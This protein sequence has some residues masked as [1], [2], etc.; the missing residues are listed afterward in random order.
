M[1]G[2]PLRPRLRTPAGRVAAALLAGGAL[3]GVGA[4]SDSAPSGPK[5]D[6]GAGA[7]P[8]VAQSGL[9]KGLA[10]PMAAY[11]ENYPQRVTI[12]RAVGLLTRDCM[13]RFGLSYDPP[14]PD[15]N[16]ASIYDDTNMVRRYG[17]TD[18]ESAAKLGYGLGTESY[19]PP[20]APKMSA[21]QVAV[22]SGRVELKPDAPEA[23]PTFNGIPIPR[24][25]C[26][27]EARNKVGGI[28]D[29]GLSG[30]LDNESFDTSKAAPEVQAALAQWSSCM[31][32]KGYTVD[33]PENAFRLA[34]R[35]SSGA[36]GSAEITLAL[37]DV[38]CK[39]SVNLVGVWFETESRIQRELI[40]KNQ[41]ALTEIRDRIEAAVKAA[42]A[43]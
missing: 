6:Q 36:V 15:A 23:P 25:G 31:A 3:L 40:E 30:R 24:E 39:E 37:A 4:C 1:T 14:A 8:A 18:R 13:A 22:F 32:G 38:D 43:R 2:E 7:P 11:M 10:L 16:P 33:L 21:A 9:T 19:T 27:R 20:P 29:T 41:L 26:R 42:A 17:L 5:D 34:P 28:L 35:N 12:D